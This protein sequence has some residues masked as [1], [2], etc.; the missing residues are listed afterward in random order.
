MSGKESELKT[1]LLSLSIEDWDGEAR[2]AVKSRNIKALRNMDFLFVRFFCKN[3]AKQ[4][5]EELSKYN[6]LMVNFL[7]WFEWGGKKEWDKAAD[8]V[9]KWKILLELSKNIVETES[10]LKAFKELKKSIYG[11]KLVELLY[12]KKILKPSEI[13]EELGIKS[14]Q[15]VSTLLSKLE[16]SG[17]IIREIDGKNVWVSLG[18]QGIAVYQEYL[19]P[20]KNE[21]ILLI[22]KVMQMYKNNELD[23]SEKELLS[24][25][26]KVPRNSLVTCI[27]G[28]INLEKG[29]L[30]EAGRLFTRTMKIGIKKENAFDFFDVLKSIH[31]F[32][33]FVDNMY[34]MNLQ[35]DKII[36]EIKPALSLYGMAHEYMGNKSRANDCYQI[37]YQAIS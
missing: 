11:E 19:E 2:K 8:L 35:K 25:M 20:Q 21:I 13:K 7:S 14:M 26:K 33:P 18:I 24:L 12:E 6:K 32:Q 34:K 10:P 17:I 22:I 28:T 5:F 29:N 27:L 31:R 1:N 9:D 30:Y 16:R 4:N 23:K 15:Q 3:V 37:L 36:K